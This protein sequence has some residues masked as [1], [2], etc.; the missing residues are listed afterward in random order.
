MRLNR[1]AYVAKS[2]IPSRHANSV[3]VMNMIRAFAPLVDTLDVYLPGNL[4]TRLRCWSGRLFAA[5]GRPQ[6]GNAR[7][8]IVSNGQGPNRNFDSSALRALRP[9]DLVFTRSATLALA[10]AERGRA[11]LF[12][13]H[14]VTRDAAQVPLERLVQALNR[15]PGSGV[16]GISQ[17]VTNAYAQAGLSTT[18]L[19]TA[20]DGVDLEA[21]SHVSAGALSRL[22]GPEIHARPVLLYTGSLS[23]EKGAG[24]LA[25]A[26]PCLDVNVAII[27]GKAEE[28]A[29]LGGK[30][31]NL[32]THPNVEHKSIPALLRDADMLIMPYLPEGDLIEFMSPLKLFEYLATGRP[33]LSAD[34]PVL[35]PILRDGDNCL[36]FTPG[37]AASLAQAMNRLHALTTDQRALL[38]RKQLATAARHSWSQ[39]AQTI[40][41]WQRALAYP[42]G[43]HAT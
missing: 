17:A 16:V 3:Q 35:G 20:P 25:Q 37:S 18:R 38:R 5:Y 8:T 14:V 19:L 42:G 22:F 10:L 2:K 9:A 26:A 27:G 41:D 6:P 36:F 31:P 39:R 32:F 33:I 24:F 21:F 12:E 4:G 30:A 1:L 43:T 40:L 13:S 23:P 29:R 11:V 34:L 7:F 15:A 28:I